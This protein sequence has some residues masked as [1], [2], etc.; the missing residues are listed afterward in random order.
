MRDGDARTSRRCAS[1][2]ARTS[3]LPGK[4]ARTFAALVCVSWC[5]PALADADAATQR[6]LMQRQQQADEFVLQLRQQQQRLQLRPGDL[7]QQQELESVQLQQ[8]QRLEALGEQQQRSLNALSPDT[9][10]DHARLLHERERADRERQSELDLAPAFRLPPPAVE[11]AA[12][13]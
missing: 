11:K 6:S 3:R 13:Q 1:V 10:L 7:R 12:P 4:R 9:G 8:R 5:L 2:C